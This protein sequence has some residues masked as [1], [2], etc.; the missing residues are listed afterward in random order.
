VKHSIGIIALFSLLIM[1]GV[2][3]GGAPGPIKVSANGRYFVDREG[4]PFFWLG[5]TPRPTCAIA[6]QRA[7]R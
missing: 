5:D 4:K 1:P 7:S 3:R 2:A 6:A